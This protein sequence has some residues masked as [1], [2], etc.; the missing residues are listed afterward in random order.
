MT[1]R[2]ARADGVFWSRPLQNPCRADVWSWPIATEP[3]RLVVGRISDRLEA[4]RRYTICVA[5]E[6][7]LV[8]LLHQLDWLS[9]GPKR[10]LQ[11]TST[12]YVNRVWVLFPLTKLPCAL[13]HHAASLETACHELFQRT[14]E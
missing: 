10:F 3:V 1:R 11:Q 7:S 9:Q 6:E 12:V 4:E 8:G 2:G 13:D 5:K 14:S